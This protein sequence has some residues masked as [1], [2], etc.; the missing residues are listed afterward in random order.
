[1]VSASGFLQA[2]YRFCAGF[3]RAG[4]FNFGTLGET[5]EVTDLKAMATDRRR[6]NQIS[7]YAAMI[8]AIVAVVA[9]LVG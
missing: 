2:H 4:V 9:V 3:S 1:M 7:L 8:G 5:H 6:G